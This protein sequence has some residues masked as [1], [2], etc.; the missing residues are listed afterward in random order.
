[1]LVAS[2]R[3]I[4]CTRSPKGFTLVELIV[5]VVVL[6]ILVAMAVPTLSRVVGRSQLAV[7]QVELAEVS[8]QAAMLAA[9]NNLASPSVSNLLTSVENT[10]YASSAYGSLASGANSLEPSSTTNPLLPSTEYGTV[11]AAW[12]TDGAD[13][14]SSTAFGLAMEFGST[15]CYA[16]QAGDGNAPQT[17]CNSACP[18][19]SATVGQADNRTS[20]TVQ[21]GFVPQSPAGVTLTASSTNA[22]QSRVSWTPPADATSTTYYEVTDP[23]NGQTYPTTS[24]SITVPG[25]AVGATVVAVTPTGQSLPSS[26]ATIATTTQLAF[27]VSGGVSVFGQTASWVATVSSAVSGPFSGSVSFDD[28]RGGPVCSGVLLS[29]GTA[30]CSSSK[31]SVGNHSIIANFSP[32]EAGYAPSTSTPITQVVSS[33]PGSSVSPAIDLGSA[34]LGDVVVLGG[35]AN[36]LS[37]NNGARVAVAGEVVVDSTTVGAMEVPPGAGLTAEGIETADV[38]ATEVCRSCSSEVSPWPPTAVAS[39]PADPL[40]SLPVPSGAALGLTTYRGPALVGP[41][42]YT[43]TVYINSSTVVPSGDYIFEAGV[44]VG[45]GADVSSAAGGVFFYNASGSVTFANGSTINLSPQSTGPWADVLLFQ[46]RDDSAAL[47]IQGGSRTSSYSGVVYLP[48]ATAD[49]ANGSGVMLGGIVANKVSVDGG[50]RV[51]LVDP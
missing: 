23:S 34:L 45:G 18:S 42:V 5:T 14:P 25:V 11:S 21:V 51:T 41:G 30:I 15:A 17:W 20:C 39:L 7:V 50:A 13:A 44:S 35:G 10:N 40:G 43:S 12:S 36:T 26:P 2:N 8:H 47:D 46:S 19:A 16:Y 22:S 37:I 31:L 9:F 27:W 24:T 38:P 48:D 28:V 3:K 49:L 6:S 4:E 29:D 33:P 1:V 32:S